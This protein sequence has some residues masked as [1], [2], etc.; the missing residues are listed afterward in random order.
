MASLQ[1]ET[2]SFY[3]F[4]HD[5]AAEAATATASPRW[6]EAT[7]TH[8]ALWAPIHAPRHRRR[9]RDL[10]WYSTAD[11][12]RML[13]YLDVLAAD[14]KQKVVLTRPDGTVTVVPGLGDPQAARI[15]LLQALTGRRASEILML[16]YDPLEAIPARTVPPRRM[17]NP[18][19][20]RSS[21]GCGINKP[22]S[23]GSS[24][25]SLAEQ[26]IVDIISEQQ[27]WLAATYPALQP[28]VPV[29]RDQNQ[30]RGQRPAPTPPT[31]R[32]WT[33]PRQLPRL[34]DSAGHRLKFTQTHRLRHPGPPNYS[35]TGFP[36]TSYSATWATR[37]PK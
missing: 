7:L 29:P 24:P 19:A 10:T 15:W 37:A 18:I 21:R 20:G 2:Q 4:M 33:K 17:P 11:L 12:Q 8:T 5:H 23:T 22:K 13:T 16:D 9:E 1:S 36:S 35:T 27:A 32:F 31:G 28:E 30:H 14:P 34:T 25:P 3:T 26:A 6:R